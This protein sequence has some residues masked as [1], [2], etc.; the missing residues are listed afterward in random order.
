MGHL[1]SL[2]REF[3]KRNHP[4]YRV[5]MVGLD[6]AGKTTMMHKLKLGEVVTSMPSIGF[7]MET[8]EYRQKPNTNKSKQRRGAKFVCFDVDGRDGIHVWRSHFDDTNAI[9]FVVDANN[10]NSFNEEDGHC[11]A[12]NALHGIL[13]DQKIKWSSSFSVGE[14][15][16]FT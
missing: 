1:W 8:V 12:K 10:L 11:P 5:A 13:A 3:E 16:R 2:L 6:S 9:I 15:T 7:R 4:L 14:Q